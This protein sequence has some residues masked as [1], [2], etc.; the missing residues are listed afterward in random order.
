MP[1]PQTVAHYDDAGNLLPAGK[2]AAA[3]AAYDDSGNP[4]AAKKPSQSWGDW[5]KDQADHIVP[6][7]LG[8]PP[9]MST[10]DVIESGKG[11]AKSGLA[12]AYG[13]R[14]LA[15]QIPGASSVIGPD[16]TPP[17]NLITPS[18]PAQQAGKTAGDMAQFAM[19]PELKVAKGGL[20]LVNLLTH[21]FEAAKQGAFSGTLSAA[22]AGGDANAAT[23]P[24]AAST[25]IAFAMPAIAKAAA[26]GG[27]K[28]EQALVKGKTPEKTATD[29]AKYDVGGSLAQTYDK[30]TK[31]ISGQFAT[32]KALLTSPAVAA[33]KINIPDVITEAA[34]A[35][36]AKQPY[37]H[38][39]IDRAMA[40]VAEHIAPAGA[41]EVDPL[42]AN[43]IKHTVG[44]MGAWAKNALGKTV[45]DDSNAIEEAANQL[46]DTLKTKLE[47]VTSG[48]AKPVNKALSDLIDIKRAVVGRLP[49]EAR[50]NVMQLGDMA[51]FASGH[52]WI[53]VLNRILKSG[54]AAQ[55]LTK[56][57]PQLTGSIA[58]P[59]VGAAVAKGQQ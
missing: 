25:A 37:G 36:K 12:T 3:I 6:S 5:L 46:Y 56:A 1:D 13:A 35:L 2:A 27:Q 14:H 33:Q 57:A 59:A 55:A 24:A 54:Q 16:I 17:T 43:Q 47:S 19:G 32:L 29:I 50:Q 38:E 34:N 41:P 4:I 23:A 9:N 15:E 30:T 49:I 28:I 51:S 18:N 58:A 26:L 31:A 53:S 44:E 7:M 22:Q 52:L 45:A 10:K 11:L 21:G 39:V 20:S 8:L 42:V 48:A 40:K